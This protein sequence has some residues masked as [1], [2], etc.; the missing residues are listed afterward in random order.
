M[1]ERNFR[2]RIKFFNLEAMYST[3]V[4]ISIS[5]KLRLSFIY[6]CF[7]SFFP[8]FDLKHSTNNSCSSFK[9]FSV[10]YLRPILCFSCSLYCKRRFFCNL[11]SKFHV[12]F[13]NF[14]SSATI[15]T[16][17]QSSAFLAEIISPVNI[18]SIDLPS[19]MSLVSL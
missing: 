8:S 16:N 15:F 13:S 9:P 10:M 6:K 12:T 2:I 3:F 5:F 11:I 1:I 14:S 4:L 7:N 17:P 19:P 18:S